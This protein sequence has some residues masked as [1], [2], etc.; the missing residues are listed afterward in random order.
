[1]N[2]TAFAPACRSSMLATVALVLLGTL[3][4]CQPKPATPQVNEG[5]PRVRVRLLAGVNRVV[6][7]ADRQTV[8]RDSAHARETGLVLD[9]SRD[10]ALTYDGNAWRCGEWSLANTPSLRIDPAADGAVSVNGSPY[11][12]TYTLEAVGPNKID[13]INEVDVENYLR[14]VLAREL[15]ADWQPEA[16]K[17]QAVIAR[18]YALY[19]I[20][21]NPPNRSWDLNPDE[22]SQVYGG[23]KAETAKATAAVAATGGI[24]VAHGQPGRERIFK[25]YFSSCCGGVAA[26]AADVFNETATPPLSA[27]DNGR[28]CAISP[29]YSWPAV[30]FSK[31]ELTRRIRAWGTKQGRAEATLPG[32]R[33]IEVAS[34]NA[35]GRPRSFVL[36]DVRGQQYLLTAEQMRWAINSE[37]NNGPTIL[38][39]YFRPVDTGDAIRLEDGHGFGHGVGACQW[40]MQGRAL[41][42]QAWQTIVV[43]QYPQ[44]VLVR[45]Y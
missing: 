40:C 29:K 32:V 12:G 43:S 33:T 18:T 30:A 1:M 41:A 22:R 21:T 4:G 37:P 27:H 39:G 17:A 25:A 13:V 10:I 28:T 5:T 19:E 45:A 2:R 7:T 34:L 44:S 14:G 11:R 15:F 24:V 3:T 20:R 31:A 6:L 8:V 23:M 42:S 16:Y 35:Y 9:P 38:S 36:T 26:S